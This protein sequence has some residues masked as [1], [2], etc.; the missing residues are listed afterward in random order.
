MDTCD[1]ED[2]RY[3]KYISVT[4]RVTVSHT[5]K[6]FY[7]MSLSSSPGQLTDFSDVGYNNYI[8]VRPILMSALYTVM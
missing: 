3:D 2:T 7:K 5:C 4:S 6:P 8:T 1:A